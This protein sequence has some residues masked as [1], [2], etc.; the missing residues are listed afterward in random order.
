MNKK[1]K[2]KRFGSLRK[3]LITVLFAAS[4][5]LMVVIVASID[6]DFN[7]KPTAGSLALSATDSA[8][9]ADETEK[10]AD[11]EEDEG[12]TQIDE[13]EAWTSRIVSEMNVNEKVGE[14]LLVRSHGLSNQEFAELAARC[15]AGG[16]VL[17]ADDINEKTAEQLTA[18]IAELQSACGERLLLCVDEEGG[19]VVRVSG[20]KLLRGSKFRS[21][22]KIYAN[23]G[24]DAIKAD[25]AEKSLF[26]KQFGINVNF[27]PVADV[28]SD[29]NGFLFK[30]AFG[31]NA[32]ETAEYVRNVVAVMG[33]NGMG[34]TI[35]HF[36]GYGNAHGDTHN[37][38][39]AVGT[40]ENE[41]RESDL[42]PFE[43]G[44]VAG[45]DSVMVT[46]SIMTELD[47]QLPSSLS[48]KVISILRDELAFDGVIISDGMD[49][50]AIQQY[51][52]GKDVCV[53]AFLAG[54]DLMCTPADADEAYKSLLEAVENG[55]ISEQ[56]LDE[57]VSRII[58]WK[59]SL[60][61]YN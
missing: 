42:I 16:V 44:I 9:I 25:A 12:L 56:R 45:A 47:P 18:D 41:I 19:T 6:N 61:L 14:L 53:A 3:L 7:T 13:T 21:P 54:I 48:P 34:S 40:S 17:F 27:A 51:G 20:N 23:G 58:R 10:G 5:M 15:H 24:I 26:L 38:L 36:P 37:G 8:T 29:S 39:V 22:Q 52:G 57:S 49:M 30:R 50:G 28:V 11:S 31:K 55:T 46:H 2:Y 59:I 1:Q 33:E 60:G 35:K 4:A 43:A 32:E